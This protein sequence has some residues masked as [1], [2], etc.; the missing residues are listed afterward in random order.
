MAELAR[1]SV[2]CRCFTD[3]VHGGVQVGDHDVGLG[4]HEREGS[5]IVV[6]DAA[7]ESR[8]GDRAV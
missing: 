6:V 2:R 4:L 5:R 7:V 8:A 3:R 1:A